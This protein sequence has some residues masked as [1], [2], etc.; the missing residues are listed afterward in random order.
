MPPP[1]IER[2][3]DSDSNSSNGNQQNKP[4]VATRKLYVSGAVQNDGY[5]TVP[6]V[7]DYKTALQIA[8]IT[9]Y[10]VMPSNLTTLISVNLDSIIVGFRCNGK[11]YYSVNVNG[12]YVK[13]RLPI[14]GID[15]KIVNKLADYIEANGI[16]TN[17]NQ[18]RLALD[19]DYADN[20][21]KFFIDVADY[22]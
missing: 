22:A 21:Y 8:V 14:D 1:F 17:R 2:E 11:A 10:S 16:I 6:Q 15:G 3:I 7:C 20:Y 9:E 5:I 13:S 12:G 4:T 19:G 18:L